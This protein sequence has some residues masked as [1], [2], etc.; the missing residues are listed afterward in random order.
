MSSKSKAKKRKRGGGS[1]AKETEGSGGSLLFSPSYL[2]SQR[3]YPSLMQTTLSAPSSTIKC[4]SNSSS[5]SGASANTGAKLDVSETQS[6]DKPEMPN[7]TEPPL[8]SADPN[9]ASSSNS[10]SSTAS[11]SASAGSSAP[12]LSYVI[13]TDS[14]HKGSSAS[15]GSGSDRGSSSSSNSESAPPSALVSCPEACTLYLSGACHVTLL[16]GQVLI[17]GYKLPTGSRTEVMCP[18][19]SPAQHLAITPTAASAMLRS[20]NTLSTSS[21]GEKKKNKKARQQSLQWLEAFAH[22]HKHLRDFTIVLSEVQNTEENPIF[23]TSTETCLLLIEAMDVDNSDDWMLKAEDYSKYKQSYN[24]EISGRLRLLRPTS[25]LHLST[26]LLGDAAA[27]TQCCIEHSVFPADWVDAVDRVC[28][29]IKSC[30]RALLCGAKGVGKSTC[31]RYTLNRLLSNKAGKCVALIDCDLGQSEFTISGLISLHILSSP[32][33]SPSHLRLRKPELS[34]FIGDTTVKAD[35]GLFEAALS[36]LYERYLVLRDQYATTGDVVGLSSY[37]PPDDGAKLFSATTESSGAHATTARSG[38]SALDDSPYS[39]FTLPLV[40]NTDGWIKSMGLEVLTT[41]I[42]TT[43]PSHV[44][45][46]CTDKNKDLPALYQLGAVPNTKAPT[47][48]TT[49][50]GITPHD[51]NS[52]TK[53]FTLKPVRNT[54]S[55]IAAVDLRNLRWVIMVLCSCHVMA[56]LVYYSWHVPFVTLL[57]IDIL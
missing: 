35:P 4:A 39:K 26:L 22:K 5:T 15:G 45:H 10:S 52:N 38:F 24:A 48:T 51:T 42:A 54:A 31:L 19:W 36:L 44:I 14:A 1:D 27:M 47:S 46:L 7:Q 57:S 50:E 11:A 41:V 20:N 37:T 30:P 6:P 13:L 56:C 16:Q 23:G 34:F 17:N 33:L 29:D 53:I 40:V 49:S 55:K 28:K 25:R 21:E 12:L 18:S 2:L 8:S 43:Q 32:I 3:A 9:S